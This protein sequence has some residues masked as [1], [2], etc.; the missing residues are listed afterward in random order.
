M[1][2]SDVGTPAVLEKEMPLISADAGGKG[3]G[4][5]AIVFPEEAAEELPPPAWTEEGGGGAGSLLDGPLAPPEESPADDVP[6][7]EEPLMDEV[8]V[9]DEP[10]HEEPLMD[11]VAVEDEPFYMNPKVQIA[12]AVVAALGVFLLGR[13]G[14]K[15]APVP[16]VQY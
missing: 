4:G 8:A 10:I 1:N 6:I 11:E 15:P 3:S 12:G 13:R 9:E 14:R 5:G 2:T 7:H 16:P